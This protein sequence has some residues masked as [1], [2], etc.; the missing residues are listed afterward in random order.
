M[1]L[2]T[3]LPSASGGEAERTMERPLQSTA[4]AAV[5][6]GVGL[7]RPPRPEC[8]EQRTLT[9][10]SCFKTQ[11]S[12][13]PGGF[14]IGMRTSHSAA[15]LS[16][17]RSNASGS[18]RRTLRLSASSALSA[19]T[20]AAEPGAAAAAATWREGGGGSSSSTGRPQRL[21]ASASAPT[22]ATAT[23]KATASGAG[24]QTLAN[25]ERT[26]AADA[27]AGA[28]RSDERTLVDATFGVEARPTATIGL[29]SGVDATV[30]CLRGILAAEISAID[31]MDDGESP[32]GRDAPATPSEAASSSSIAENL[33]E[34]ANA[35]PAIV[36]EELEENVEE[37]D[38]EAND[39]DDPLG[40]SI[41]SDSW[42]GGV[43]LETGAITGFVPQDAAA[44]TAMDAKTHQLEAEFL[45]DALGGGA[46][47]AAPLA[48]SKTLVT[49]GGKQ[50]SDD[51]EEEEDEE[52]ED[53]DEEAEDGDD[54]EE[55]EAEG[56]EEDEEE[57]EE[58]EDEAEE[59]EAE[60]TAS[61][62]RA[63]AAAESALWARKAEEM[64]TRYARLTAELQSP[65]QDRRRE[66][67]EAPDQAT[68]RRKPWLAEAAALPV[69]A[70]AGE[71]RTEARAWR[72]SRGDWRDTHEPLTTAGPHAWPTRY[73]WRTRGADVS[74]GGTGTT[75]HF[76]S[77][78]RA[79][80]QATQA[81]G[82]TPIASDFRQRA[83]GAGAHIST[84]KRSA[85]AAAAAGAVGYPIAAG[86]RPSSR[87]APESFRVPPEAA[88]A[89]RSRRCL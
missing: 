9:V 18:A 19:G 22:L 79:L 13:S 29:A 27:T 75:R 39:D 34:Q 51:D 25:V 11:R 86:K 53:S 20:A 26:M 54:E 32:E 84:S 80:A 24:A 77:T 3:E 35:E 30:D 38:E 66:W 21:S 10:L 46:T 37:E 23:A 42:N 36:P 64:Q 7:G 6:G 73:G 47:L 41:A 55:D 81:L 83:S 76:V 5:R 49:S 17:A 40:L 71:A 78:V 57:D 63:T 62:A 12:V 45:K 15:S 59:A 14:G 50:A 72:P 85:A 68:T 74:G 65:A 28:G 31:V 58:A 56:E 48:T 1:L 60:E 52:E 88:P 69:A 87:E 2:Q 70:I 4:A 8:V 43:L 82:L 67:S 61:L 44:E 33:A 16:G 89:C